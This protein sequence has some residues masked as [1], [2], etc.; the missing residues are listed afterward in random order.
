VQQI[1]AGE[2]FE[3]LARK[4][5]ARAIARRSKGVFARV[6]LREADQLLDGACCD[7]R[8]YQEH[9]VLRRDERHRLEVAQRIVRKIL[10]KTDV[11]CA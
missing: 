10:V 4:V 1:D 5:A 11:R 7:R 6:C 9:E 2:Q 3:E 8:M